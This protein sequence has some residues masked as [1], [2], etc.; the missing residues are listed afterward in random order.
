VH[1]GDPD[2]TTARKLLYVGFTR[3]VDRLAVVV[4]PASPFHDDVVRAAPGLISRT[5]GKVS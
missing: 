1:D 4:G 2:L 5:V 3:A